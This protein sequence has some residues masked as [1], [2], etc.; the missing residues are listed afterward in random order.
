MIRDLLCIKYKAAKEKN[1][2]LKK[3]YKDREEIDY[4]FHPEAGNQLSLAFGS[5]LLI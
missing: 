5:Y 4:N 2:E 3:I 1:E